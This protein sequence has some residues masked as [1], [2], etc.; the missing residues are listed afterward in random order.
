MEYKKAEE[1]YCNGLANQEDRD[2]VASTSDLA[3]M[4]QLRRDPKPSRGG[5]RKPTK[6]KNTSKAKAKQP[7]LQ[8]VIKKMNQNFQGFSFAKCQQV[9]GHGDLIVYMPSGYGNKT[10]KRNNG[11][12]SGS[13][14]DFC[15]HCF[16]QPCSMREYKDSF[17]AVLNENNNWLY[18]PD[19]ELLEKLRTR[20]RVE[21]MK[22]YNKTYVTKFMP[23]NNDIP[24]CALI[25]TRELIEDSGYDSLLDQSPFSRDKI[26]NKRD[27]DRDVLER[28]EAERELGLASSSE[29]HDEDGDSFAVSDID[30]DLP[31]SKLK[32]NPK[33]LFLPEEYESE[34]EFEF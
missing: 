34:E 18:L 17:T 12:L 20:Y 26:L 14:R 19:D 32:D 4:E 30:D 5:K 16:L 6:K 24:Q 22:T 28:K 25:G 23:T 7:T 3:I 10:K 21:A 31:I 33:Q 11:I 9:P 29:E 13:D 27:N 8:Q 2:Y 15:K 1:E